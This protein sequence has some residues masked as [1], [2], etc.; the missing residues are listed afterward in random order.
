MSDD[1]SGFSLRWFERVR[2][3]TRRG[4]ELIPE[5][6]VEWT[7]EPGRFTLGDLV[8]H[9]AA[10]ERW[11]FAENVEGRPSRYTGCGID[12]AEGKANV[13]A[14]MDRRHAES[15]EM[16]GRLSS[17]DMLR[18]CTTPGGARIRTWKWLRAMVEHEIHHRGQLYLMLRMLGVSV[19]PIFGLTEE[20]LR[21]ERTPDGE[22]A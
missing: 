9:L 1:P 10:T 8:R 13:I 14:Y 2:E 3:R 12:L 21:E 22:T 20:Q 5:D 18:R 6:R 16:F 15:M 4:V 11:M 19:P 7:H 17:D